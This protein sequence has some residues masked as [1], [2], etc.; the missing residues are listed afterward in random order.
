MNGI[1]NGHWPTSN[2]HPPVDGIRYQDYQPFWK[3]SHGTDA[4]A[5][6]ATVKNKSIR[7]LALQQNP[8]ASF[9]C[10]FVC[11]PRIP[12]VQ[13]GVVV[14]ANLPAHL[15]HLAFMYQN[16]NLPPGQNPYPR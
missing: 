14:V 12:V 3:C 1:I 4:A 13:N 11:A 16:N 8:Q 7:G 6:L 10:G 15:A 2:Q 5:G 9:N